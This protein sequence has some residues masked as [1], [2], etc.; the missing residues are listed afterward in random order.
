MYKIYGPAQKRCMWGSQISWKNWGIG[1]LKLIVVCKS[2]VFLF[3]F[4]LTLFSSSFNSWPASTRQWFIILHSII[5]VSNCKN[6]VSCSVVGKQLGF[7]QFVIKRHHLINLCW[8][9]K[10]EA[11][12]FDFM[13]SCVLSVL[14]VVTLLEKWKW[15]WFCNITAEIYS[16]TIIKLLSKNLVYPIDLAYVA[17]HYLSVNYFCHKIFKISGI[18]DTNFSIERLHVC[19]FPEMVC[20]QRMKQ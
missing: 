20:D 3:V 7:V 6:N 2:P 1:G 17:R 13:H 10:N 12:F 9:G 16:N 19:T 4:L 18:R 15:S 14:C 8:M 5:Q 11:C